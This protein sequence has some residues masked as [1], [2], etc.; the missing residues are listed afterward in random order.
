MG[1]QQLPA[2]LQ[3]RLTPGVDAWAADC[4]GRENG[5]RVHTV[6]PDRGMFIAPASKDLTLSHPLLAW[7]KPGGI[8]L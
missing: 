7:V 2:C 3:P 6:C 5:V 4:R 1:R 8:W